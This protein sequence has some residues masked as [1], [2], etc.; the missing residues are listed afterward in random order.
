MAHQYAPAVEPRG[1]VL[2]RRWPDTPDERQRLCAPR[3]DVLLES[4]PVDATQRPDQALPARFAQEDGPFTHYG[5]T[6]EAADDEL[7]ET[8]T[9]HLTIPWFGWL[10]RWPVGRVIA[11]TGSPNRWWAPPDRLDATQILVV[12]LLA[13]A[14]MS[15]AFVNTLF[16]QTVNFAAD[17][18]GVSDTAIGVAGAVVRAGIVLAIPAAVIADR[19][20]RRRVIITVAW[21]APL[22]SVLGA[23]AP[24]F[25]VLVAT[26]T[27]A[28]PMGIALAFLVGVVA[29]EEMPRNSRT[30]AVSILAM[31]A[32]LGAGIA[33]IALSLADLGT[34]GWRFVYLLAAI[35]CIVALDLA[36]RLPETRR[37]SAAHIVARIRPPRMNRRRLLLLSSVAFAGNI[38]V[39]PASLFQNNY[40]TDVRGFSGGTIAVFSIAVGTPASIGLIV[41]GR[42]A[43]SRGR[44]RLIAVT[45]PLGTAGVVGAFAVGGLPLWVLSLLGGLLLSAAYPALAVYRTELFPTGNRSRATGLVTAAALIGGIVGLLSMGA[46]LDADWSY[47]AVLAT[48]AIGQLIVTV[49]VVVAYPETAHLELEAL[50][51]EDA[52][53]DLH[54]MGAEVP[55]SASEDTTDRTTDR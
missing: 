1:R 17:D 11:R 44:R 6:V 21:I 15:A 19:I 45:V 48:F 47:A 49:L 24:S 37:F 35:W 42:I 38:F 4:R 28:R 40:L 54:H 2:I 43:D 13:A 5:R 30:Y 10:F 8:T 46:L 7:V 52:P 14:S 9:Y 34:G 29:S 55:R 20:G 3:D 32:G 36:R 51:P 23:F 33:V 25:A 18:F 39:A 53:I 22:L 27:V 26:Q 16:T 50:N 31:A 12:G 41:G